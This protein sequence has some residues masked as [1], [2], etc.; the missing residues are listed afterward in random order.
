MDHRP[1][2]WQR[3]DLLRLVAGLPLVGLLGAC[4]PSPLIVPDADSSPMPAPTLDD[5][6][7]SAAQA[8]ASLA[9]LAARSAELPDAEPA[10]AAWC[11]ALAEQHRAHQVVLSQ[12]DPL[13]GVQ[14]DHTALEAI[15]PDP[16]PP[17]GSAAEAQA[18]LAAGE[19]SLAEQLARVL[20]DPPTTPSL[21]LLW[22]SQWLAA[23]VTAQVFAAETSAQ[24]GPAP[25]VGGAVPAETEMGGLPEA[26]QVLLS[27]QRALVFGLQ[28]LLGRAAAGDPAQNLLA[29]RLGEAM[30]ERDLSAAAIVASGASPAP[31][32]PVYELPGD[33]DDPAQRAQIW[34][35]LEAGV[36]AG[37]ARLAAVAPDERQA[38]CQAALVQ[39]GRSRG[40][41]QALPYWPGWV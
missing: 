28:T 23:E 32:A 29:T 19:R 38:A 33:A 11:S 39:A 8:A 34:G 3:R 24:F 21:A 14:A 2:G 5:A 7:R 15:E 25:V 13:G 20:V 10:F 41:G 17:L 37:W 18:L 35:R 6:R 12:A 30:R 26:R 31:V 40:H 36:L 4:A 9:A 22:I 27:H 16:T 1:D